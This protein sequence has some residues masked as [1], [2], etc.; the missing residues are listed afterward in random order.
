M[1]K[2]FFLG[3]IL[4]TILLFS[5]CNDE[6]SHLYLTAHVVEPTC[7][8]EGYTLNTCTECS[9]EF[10]SDYVLPTGHVITETVFAPTCADVGYTYYSCE[11]GYNYKA[12]YTA[13]IGHSYTETLHAVSCESAGYTEYTCSLCSHSY[14]GNFVDTEGHKLTSV[15]F[16]PTKDS[17]GYTQYTCEKCKLSYSSDFVFYSDVYGGGYV[18]NTEVLAQGIDVSVNQHLVTA[19]GYRPL[20][21]VAIKNAGIDFAILKAGSGYS[22]M[23]P[24]FEMNYEGAK[25]AGVDVG[26]YFYCYATTEEELYKEIDVLLPLLEGKQFEYPIYFDLEDPSLE[27]EEN[28][29]ML[30]KFCMIFIDAL[31]ENGY[32]GALYCNNPWLTNYLYGETLKSYC[33][34]WYARWPSSTQATLDRVFQWNTESYGNQL[35][36][37][38]YTDNGTLPDCGL[39]KGQAIDFNYA[40]K[41][42]PSIIKAYGLNGFEAPVA[43]EDSDI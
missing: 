10:R 28:K 4:C 18:E 1:K 14:K 8:N 17:V 5:S 36:M 13:P 31:R 12:N 41:N 21:W 33:D 16:L 43:D 39:R 29:E 26:A 9:A 2:M 7:D 40:Y 24:V 11:C 6:C 20:D 38:Q 37:W 25:A 35:G 23:D 34:I 27:N 42:Y 22:G 32:Y 30:T 15:I 19:S 3:A